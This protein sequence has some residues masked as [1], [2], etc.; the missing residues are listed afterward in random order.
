MTV[1]ASSVQRLSSAIV[2][3]MITAVHLNR[4]L[5][6]TLSSQGFTYI[7]LFNPYNKVDHF[8]TSI[9]SGRKLKLQRG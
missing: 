9:F 3:V 5:T 2:M 6:V 4:V 8:I 7:E 1:Q